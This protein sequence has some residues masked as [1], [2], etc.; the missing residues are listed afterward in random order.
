[1]TC[2]FF[3]R[4][5]VSGDWS[6]V[7]FTATTRNKTTGVVDSKTW[8]GNDDWG[9]TSTSI[10]KAVK[11]EGVKL[12]PKGFKDTVP[13]VKAGID[14]VAKSLPT[15]GQVGS[16]AKDLEN[17]ARGNIK[18]ASLGGMASSA[19]KKLSDIGKLG[20][21]GK[22]A[23]LLGNGL[24]GGFNPLGSALP[25]PSSAGL[26]KLAKPVFTS[27]TSTEAATVDIYADVLNTPQNSI[28]TVLHKVSDIVNKSVK[29]N[30]SSLLMDSAKKMNMLQ[31]GLSLASAGDMLDSM[32][33]SVL[34][35]VPLNKENINKMML[36]TMG[37]DGKSLGFKGGIQGIG[38][39]MLK[40]IK[41]RVD[42]ETGILTMYKG[43]KTIIDGKED[44]AATIFKI[45]ENVTGNTK[46]A[47][48]VN[49]TNTFKIYKTIT[50]SLIGLGAPKFFDDLIEKIDHK[51]RELYL[52][53]NL[54][55]G[56]SSGDLDFME[57]VFKHKDGAWIMANQPNAIA[58]FS[59]SYKPILTPQ[60]EGN[61]ADNARFM[62]I[63]N[64]IN[65]NWGLISNKG[66]VKRYDLHCFS[67]FNTAAKL[68]LLS[69][70]DRKLISLSISSENY[71][72]VYS[73]LDEMIKRYPEYPI[74]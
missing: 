41:D 12:V 54:E 73:I 3:W 56:L 55:G 68:A 34:S 9:M 24:S 38:E 48:M 63:L 1:M 39:S 40:D 46:V 33:N 52:R 50:Q 4:L 59:G 15:G 74:R 32:K 7:E 66:G 36:D 18:I 69:T 16:A 11:L 61:V 21:L 64:R 10:S 19:A 43:V 57:F 47:G 71:T 51:D 42:G 20:G 17:L 67:Q 58:L 26:V 23:S 25:D 29:G 22:G 53:D 2:S 37:Y 35:G 8:H 28:R 72:G 30:L 44:T 6:K 27:G 65:P 5:A 14:K 62:S 13:N 49:L 31:N 45:L 60:G 70:R